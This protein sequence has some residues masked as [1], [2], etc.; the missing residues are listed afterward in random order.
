MGLLVFA[1]GC[2]ESPAGAST[3]TGMYTLRTVNGSTPPYT[4]TAG[5]EAGTV[6]VD[7]VI[8]I[9]EARTFAQTR[10]VRRSAAG[11]VETQS[12]T[13]AVTFFGT[14]ITLSVNETGRQKVAIGDG[15]SMTFVEEG[16]TMVY[17][18]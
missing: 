5:S 11:P 2:S 16:V 9:Y 4:L 6:I 7:D 17:R 12:F 1:V 18:K 14:S 15:T 10:H 8:W 13:G 3:S